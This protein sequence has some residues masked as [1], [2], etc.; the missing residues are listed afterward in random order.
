MSSLTW[1]GVSPAWLT[2]TPIAHRGLHT[3]DGLRPENSLA[4]FEAAARAGYAIEL[5]VRQLADGHVVVFHDADLERLTGQSGTIAALQ[6]PDLQSLRL[7]EG[8]EGVP[9]LADVLAQID[10]Q[11]PLLIEI[12]SQPPSDLRLLCSGVAQL[13]ADYTG[14]AAIQ[15]FEPR[16]LL[17]F[18]FH[19]P[20]IPRGLLAD[21]QENGPPSRLQRLLLRTLAFAPLVWPHFIGYEHLALPTPAIRIA[22]AL[23][24]PVLAWTVRTPGDARRARRHADNIIFEGFRPDPAPS[25]K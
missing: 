9:L 14:P 17:W 4:A 3:G 25:P 16:V 19:A 12:K 5:D 11:V 8:G 2:A 1:L 18:R 23:G 13:L 24:T 15:S 21:A 6:A 20:G 22:R 10:G 7:L